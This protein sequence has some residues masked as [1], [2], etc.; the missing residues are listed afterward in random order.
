LKDGLYLHLERPAVIVLI[1]HFQLYY[2]RAVVAAGI[3]LTPNM[4]IL[5]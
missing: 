2:I 5:N 1:D 3:G 4:T